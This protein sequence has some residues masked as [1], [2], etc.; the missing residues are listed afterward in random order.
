MSIDILEK[1]RGKKKE[2]FTL[3]ETLIALFILT[4]GVGG[5]FG[6][7]HQTISYM[8]F[9]QNRLVA[10]YLAQEGIEIV[11]NIRDENFLKIHYG[12]DIDWLE[13]IGCEGGGG[14]QV[15]YRDTS[16]RAFEN[17]PLH[18]SSKDGERGFF[19][20][21][22]SGDLIHNPTPSIFTREIT[23]NPVQ[24]AGEEKVEVT[25]TVSW[26]RYDVQVSTELHKWL[27]E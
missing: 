1:L 27:G 19:I 14:C 4:V 24:D 11:R 10:S 5:A 12:G 25:A 9:A 21:P 16:L 3:V 18:I 17:N 23:I 22:V 8:A 13:G 6:L 7:I 20:Q 2:G 15:D 26:S